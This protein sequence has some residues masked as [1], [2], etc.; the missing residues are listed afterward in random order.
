MKRLITKKL[1]P[2]M[3]LSDNVYAH[4]NNQLI[5]PKGCVLDNQ[6]I[7]KLSFYSVLNVLVE[8]PPEEMV[9]PQDNSRS[10]AARLRQTEEFK[11]FKKDFEDCASKFKAGIGDLINDK[12]HFD[13][14]SIISPI[15][16][17]VRK[18]N[19]SSNLFDMLHSL[20]TYDDATYVHC[21]SVAM[22]CNILGQWLKMSD[23]DIMIL[24]EAGLLHDIGKL[25]IPNEIITK[26]SGL[27]SD[28]YSVVQT[29]PAQ[30]YMILTDLDLSDH[31]KN[32]ALMHHER[33]DGTGYP[34][35]LKGPQIDF[36]AKCVSIAD[37]Y[38]AMTS[39]RVYRDP[40]CPFIAIEM[41][42][43]EGLQKYDTNAIMTFLQNI[44][45]TYLLNRVR[46]NDGREGEIIFINRDHLSKPT[47]KIDND[48]LDLSQHSNLYIEEIL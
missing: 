29:H 31:V 43:S 39:A 44:V 36:F 27:S 1:V 25:L 32:A 4:D 19:S 42:E 40:L 13:I 33:C 5:L 46:L 35:H 26:P 41:F 20:R 28:E 2:G 48:Y 6:A 15:Y 14:D 45:N 21:I 47:I 23:D 17:L 8:D 12:E 10:Y 22:I 30:G 34:A 3:I 24:T 16:D 37:V 38:D 9:S 18:G 11:E 7:T